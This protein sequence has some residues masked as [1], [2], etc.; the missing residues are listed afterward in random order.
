[1]E[2]WERSGTLELLGG[3]LA[4]SA[5]GGRVVVVGGEAGVGKS[6]LVGEFVRRFG[7]GVR[8]LRGGC[9]RL[10]T[11]RVLGPLRDIGRQ[12]GGGLAERLA[13]GASREE[14][15]GGFLD[16]ISGPGPRP[17]VVV[18]DVHWADEG[19]LDW[20]VWSGRRIAQV[21]VLFVVTYRDDE[22]GAD[23]PLRGALA[24]LPSSVTRRVSLAPLSRECV[25]REA[26]GA[27]WDAEVVH[28][29]SGGNPLLV[30]EL[31][32]AERRTVPPTVQDLILD[33]L[34]R[35]P[36][37]AAD[38]AR[39]VSVV[40]TRADGVIVADV[41]EL[42]DVCVDAGVLVPSGDGVAYRH[43]LL[44]EAVEDALPP[45][46]RAALHRRVLR[47]LAGAEGVDPGRLVHH[48]TRAGDHAAVLRYGQV[49]GAEAARQGA[50]REAAAH[51]R[52]AAPH[53]ERLPAARRAELLEEYALQAYLAGL[54]E[55]G[56]G[57]R[58]SALAV[59]EESRQP[60]AAGENLR[61]ISRLAWWSGDTRAAWEAAVR[62]VAVLEAEPPG[63]ALAMAYSN[64]S[65]LHMLAGDGEEAVVWGERARDLADRLGDAETSV[66]AAINVHTA[67]LLAGDGSAAGL[68]DAHERAA[69]LGLADHAA[70]ALVNLAT[71]LVQLAEYDAAAPAVEEALAYA[72][73]QDL[74][75]Y[76]QYLL[77]VRA[78]VRLVRCD[79][80][81]AL[82]DADA[83]LDRPV[84]AGVAVVPALLAR[85]RIQAA[86]GAPEARAT[87]DEAAR[88]ARR[89]GEVQRVCPVASVRSEYFLMYGD[90][91]RATE[92]ARIGLEPA[93][94][95]RHPVY[96]GE[97]A[98][99]LWRAGGTEVPGGVVGPYRMMID[100]DWA[101][102]AAEWMRRGAPYA[103]VEALADGDRDAA[104]EALRVLDGLGAVRV[105]DD[106]RARLRRR[107]VTG[108][109]RGPRRATAANP[110]GLTPR[111]AEVL[112]LLAE[113]LSNAEIAGRLSLSAK[114][115]DHHISAVLA[116]LGV[117]S[118][119]QAVA[120]AHRLDLLGGSA[121]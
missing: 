26:A 1:M 36:P 49:A 17:V 47:L 22:V 97:L 91:R 78:G 14:V 40:P 33:R 48:A 15:F 21:P 8:V 20:L 61:W 25:A 74:D 52:A 4:E 58:R 88:Q 121:N 108:V 63:R 83:A 29:L 75:G 23:H 55:E 7:V 86:R 45:A 109:P 112:A 115:V 24:A 39:L 32:K 71:T 98:Y 65:Q 38:L 37:G 102:A 81:G 110:G 94:A 42:V 6:V 34:R 10:V 105:A 113:G 46:R 16:V 100:G 84:R 27:G 31:L 44:R 2:L 114:T 68:R 11:P 59:R 67:R 120:A 118:R 104:T 76:V 30:T 18:E 28:R 57:A 62:A 80:A 95:A 5:R 50:H 101:G 85:G 119:G 93:V 87:L 3:L 77:G 90:R 99:R 69:G 66:H 111:Q 117:T 19:T 56:L 79:W 51:Y 70:R 53:V 54:A 92:E 35:L 116:K 89:T 103:R 43:E 13:G 64:R 82:A 41:P 106:V 72:V 60:G 107:G 9:D 73:E 96:G 12:V